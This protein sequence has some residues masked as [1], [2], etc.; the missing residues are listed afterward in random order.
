VASVHYT[1]N[2]IKRQFEDIQSLIKKQEKLLEEMSK[3]MAEKDSYIINLETTVRK[4]IEHGLSND[5]ILDITGISI[6][7][8]EDIAAERRYYYIPYIYLNEDEAEEYERLLREIHHAND[9]YELINPYKEQ[10]RI[11]FIHKVML[12][13][14]EEYDC[15]NK[16]K[17]SDNYEDIILNYIDRTGKDHDAKRAYSILVRRFGN[18]IKRMR[19]KLLIKISE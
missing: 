15:L 9:I 2:K 4:L 3:A 16:S 18:D 5:E 6:E 17:S 7:R 8:Y 14:K 10:E 19:E 12:R 13:Y 11:K 1:N